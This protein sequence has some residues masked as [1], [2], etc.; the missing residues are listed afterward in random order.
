MLAPKYK[1]DALPNL[2]KVDPYLKFWHESI[3]SIAKGY[4]AKPVVPYDIDG[5]LSASGVLDP[6]REVKERIKAFAYAYRMTG[7]TAWV[8]RTWLELQ[9]RTSPSHCS[10]LTR[11]ML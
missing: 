6:S 9:V 1:W 3:I 11:Y 4:S 8:D 2:I 10:S 7:D 5:G